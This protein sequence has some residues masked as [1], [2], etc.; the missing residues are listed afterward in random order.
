MSSGPMSSDRMYNTAGLISP[1]PEETLQIART[2]VSKR[3][4]TTPQPQQTT[5]NPKPRKQSRRPSVLESLRS[6]AP[7]NP[8]A[9]YLPTRTRRTTPIPAYE[10][11][12]DVFT[13]PR[14]VVMTPTISKSSKRKTTGRRRASTAELFV[15]IEP[16]QI[17]LSAPQP[18]P[19]PTDDP[20]LLSAASSS[21]VRPRRRSAVTMTSTPTPLPP[22]FDVTDP[23][24]GDSDDDI[25][26]GEG[27]YTGT[28]RSFSVRTKLD[29]PSSATRERQEEW[30]RPITPFPF[31][32]MRR[33][34]RTPEPVPGPFDFDLSFEEEDMHEK[35]H[36]NAD[37][38][39]NVH[40]DERN[41]HGDERNVHGDE[42][43]VHED[44]V[45]VHEDERNVHEDEV[46]VHED[47]RNVH[48]DE[49]NVHEDE[50]NVHEDELNMHEADEGAMH[51][52]DEL[53]VHEADNPQVHEDERNLHEA[54]KLQVHEADEHN[55][56][57]ADEH[58]VH[59]A[60]G[61][62]V[63][64]TTS[65]QDTDQ[66]ESPSHDKDANEEA[67]ERQ[68]REMSLSLDD[69]DPIITA[70][71]VPASP[72][73]SAADQESSSDEEDLEY[74]VVKISSADPH[75]AARAAAI[76]KQHDY[77]CFTKL[78]LRSK[79]VRHSL[80]DSGIIKTRSPH[81]MR[82]R[83]LGASIIG[84]KVFIPGSP[85]TTLPE[86]LKQAEAAVSGTP[87]KFETSSHLFT[88]VPRPSAIGLARSL[89]NNAAKERVWSKDEWKLLDACFT[90]ERIAL[91]DGQLAPVDHV[92]HENVVRRF[93]D[94]L[95]GEEVVNKWG[96][97]WETEN[98]VQR[99]KA[100]QNKQRKGIVA[101]PTTP[102]TPR[103]SLTDPPVAGLFSHRFPSM[104]V[105][106][107]TPLGRRA[108]PPAHRPTLPPPV[109]AGAPF[110]DLQDTP[111]QEH[112]RPKRKLPL[113]LLAP[114][115]SHLLE[116]AV[117]VSQL[118][119][120]EP[121]KMYDSSHETDSEDDAAA[122]ASTETEAEPEPVAPPSPPPQS[123]L[124]T[125]VKSFLFSYLPTLSKNPALKPK[126]SSRPGLPLP[127]LSVLEKS[128]G[129][130]IT[131]AR[132][133]MPKPTHPKELVHLNPAPVPPKPS[134]IPRA[135]KPQRLVEL[136]RVSPPHEKEKEMVVRARRSS[137][138]SVKD[139]VRGFEEMEKNASAKR[140]EE[141]KRGE[142]KRVRSV[143]E[144][145]KT[146]GLANAGLNGS[147]P[148]WRP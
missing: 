16:P 31:R 75:A 134:M 59:E 99:V 106:D 21:P 125:R 122:N 142:L 90:D 104:E 55:V 69:N 62:N 57:E 45:N 110:S 89:F 56:H 65:H 117:A 94:L 114:R 39:R 43:N 109:V 37:E 119:E 40:G 14:V 60:H 54:D 52:A 135:P 61:H 129:P 147:K 18:P 12:A 2:S 136:H 102:N 78:A 131:P 93:V 26:D 116:E 133:P 41:V 8:N 137:G 68:V 36:E 141:Q 1:P 72:K 139:L 29:P 32:K 17:D 105:P 101:P 79:R 120:P 132:A 13:P 84:D 146:A 91:G 95:G 85:A 9:D 92:Q 33:D 143:G 76:L 70:T 86:L 30:G 53:N 108:A 83:T 103:P 82:R 42:R 38:E 28:F 107:F 15:K 46:N 71:P 148:S 5:P 22:L 51:E 6:P 138:G 100:L 47:E 118:P 111:E 77:D 24:V 96:E 73:P 98:L 87:A 144:W 7:S 123:T 145:R 81:H 19:S 80:S 50:R 23:G 67:D 88:P 35:V 58:N 48:E 34:E 97:D 74:G 20:L 113:S 49:V 4:R 130:I 66:R 140:V 127:P 10:P 11:P 63:H 126:S 128:R 3:K 27:D 64:E 124:K 44:E 115:Y 121:G 25:P 112:E